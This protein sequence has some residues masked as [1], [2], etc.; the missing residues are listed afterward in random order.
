MA[1]ILVIKH[2]ALGDVVMAT[3]A[4]RAI[5]SHHGADRLTLLTTARYAPL[6]ER[7]G[8]FDAIWLDDRPTLTQPLALWRLRSRLAEAG[9]TRVYDL[10]TSERTA[11]YFR[12]WPRPRPEW[13]G[14]APGCSHPHTDPERDRLHGTARLAG[15]L[16]SVGIRDVPPPSLAFLEADLSAFALPRRLALLVPGSSPHRPQKRWPAEHYA[17]LALRLQAAGLTPVLVG[18]T[19]EARLIETIRRQCPGAV[20]LAGRTDVAQLAALGRRARLAVG[21]DT[22]PMH[23]LAAAPCPALTLF[24]AASEPLQCAPAGPASTWLRE[25]DLAALPVERV[26]D[27]LVARGLTGPDALA[28]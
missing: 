2:G 23:V 5:R 12:I 19:A 20:D 11:F 4:M 28:S 14:I 21:N 17:A 8:W 26:W 10:Q 1:A 16:A 7:S 13:V 24:G 6:L 15:Q 25:A 9:F 27:A 18:G 3:G 22:G